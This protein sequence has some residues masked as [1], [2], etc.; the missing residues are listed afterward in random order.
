MALTGE[1]SLQ[2][3]APSISQRDNAIAIG[4]SLAI[5]TMAD[6]PPSGRYYDGSALRSPAFDLACEILEGTTAY[7]PRLR[8][9]QIWSTRAPQGSPTFEICGYD[10]D[11]E[12]VC[13]RR[14]RRL[15]DN[16]SWR[17]L[18]RLCSSTAEMNGVAGDEYWPIDQILSLDMSNRRVILTR[19]RQSSYGMARS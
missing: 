1:S 18:Q 5:Y 9:G 6:F 10:T 4:H 17:M 7:R 8:V 19:R 2:A 12:L 3:L 13:I 11:R 15:L 16:G 14:W